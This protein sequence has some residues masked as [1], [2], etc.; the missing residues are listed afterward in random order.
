MVMMVSDHNN[1]NDNGDDGQCMTIMIIVVMIMVMMV[2]YNNNCHDN[3]D[4]SNNNK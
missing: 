4:D 1:C 2:K 3:D